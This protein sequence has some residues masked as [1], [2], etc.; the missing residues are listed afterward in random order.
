MRRNPEMFVRGRITHRDHKTVVLK[1]WH[2]VLMNTE[3]RAKARA[4]VL[5]LD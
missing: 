1:G 5:F 2:Q 4:Q 3:P